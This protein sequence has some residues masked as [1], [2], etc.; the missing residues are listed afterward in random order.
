V[1]LI[2]TEGLLQKP[3]CSALTS[4]DWFHCRDVTRRGYLW[5]T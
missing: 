3:P 5:C 1:V 4:A 2:T